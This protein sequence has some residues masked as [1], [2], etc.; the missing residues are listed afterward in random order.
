MFRIAWGPMRWFLLLGGFAAITM[1]WR[2][3]YIL[4]EWQWDEDIIK[5]ECVHLSQIARDGPVWFT[6][7]YLWWLARYGY[8]ANPYEIEAYAKAPVK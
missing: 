2:R 6:V 3:V 8:E 5:H 1:P 4:D 7:R